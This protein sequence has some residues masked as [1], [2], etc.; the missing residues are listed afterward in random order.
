MGEGK[1]GG[2]R[3]SREGRVGKGGRGSG[4]ERGQDGKWGG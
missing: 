4:E 3:V 2:R 1:G